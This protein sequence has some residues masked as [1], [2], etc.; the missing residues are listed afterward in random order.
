MWKIRAHSHPGPIPFPLMFT[1]NSHCLP[2]R[3]ALGPSAWRRHTQLGPCVWSGNGSQGP[4][5]PE[6]PQPWRWGL[7]KEQKGMTAPSTQPGNPSPPTR[8]PLLQLH[9]SSAHSFRSASLGMGRPPTLHPGKVDSKM[10]TP[11]NTLDQAIMAY[12][13]PPSLLL[14]SSTKKP[15]FWVLSPP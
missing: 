11:R 8:P 3:A 14:S 7:G 12:E 10:R 2:R 13:P 9:S 15:V 5:S 6:G 4:R 1:Q